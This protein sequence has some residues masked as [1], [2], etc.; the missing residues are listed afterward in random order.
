MSLPQRKLQ[1]LTNYDYSQCGLYFVTICTFC[2]QHLF[3]K[4]EN[5]MMV[6][7]DYGIIAQTHLL[8]IKEHFPS[9][10]VNPYIIMPNHV[11]CVVQMAKK[12][13]KANISSAL[14]DRIINVKEQLVQSAERSRPFPT[15]STVIGLYKSGV[16]KQIHEMNPLPSVWQKSFHDHI[17]RN[18][19]E[20][21]QIVQYILFNDLNWQDDGLL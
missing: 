16:S 2:R 20:Y 1:R 3:G 6:L 13:K 11:H 10:E 17:I 4:I 21:Q 5:G 15:V 12:N 14:P 8:Y 7:N 19:Q 9:V 18:E